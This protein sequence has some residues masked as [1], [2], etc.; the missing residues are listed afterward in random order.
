MARKLRHGFGTRTARLK[1]AIRKKPYSGPSLVP[2]VTLLY[3]RNRGNGT[4]IVQAAAGDGRS[5][6]TKAFAAADD[7]AEAGETVLTF[8]ERRTWRRS[9][10]AA[11]IAQPA[12]RPLSRSRARSTPIK[13]TSRRAM[14]RSTTRNTTRAPVAAAD[15]TGAIDTAPRIEAHPVFS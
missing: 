1:L 5:Y 4:W 10:R 11:V 9:W 2:R 6:W 3:R 14:P 15:L 7:Y 8:F 12:R 13:P